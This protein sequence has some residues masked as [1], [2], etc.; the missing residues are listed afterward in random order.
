MS[1]M[2]RIELEGPSAVPELTLDKTIRVERRHGD[3][4]FSIRSQRIDPETAYNAVSNS[5]CYA[6]FFALVSP[7][8]F[9]SVQPL[10]PLR[11]G[12]LAALVAA[13]VCNGTVIRNNDQGKVFVIKG[14]TRVI[15]EEVEDTTD[16]KGNRTT[17]IRKSP[18]P[19]VYLLD[20][21]EAEILELR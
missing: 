17:I 10:T 15:E 6:D 13:G 8:T 16:E 3:R 12:H 2:Y 7:P 14:R 18:S 1:L 4:P 5:R 11:R 19:V 20:A 21:S 9:G